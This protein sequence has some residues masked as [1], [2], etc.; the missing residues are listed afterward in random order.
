MSNPS[1]PKTFFLISLITDYAEPLMSF[2]HS[3][4]HSTPETPLLND[5]QVVT[6][7]FQHID[8][9][10]T[11]LGDTVWHEP[12]AHYH[13]QARFDAEI[14][15]L[16]SLPL[17]FCPSAALPEPGSYV[18]RNAAGTPLLVVR[19]NDG[20][21]RAF[22]NACR[23]RG[24]QVASGSGCAKAFVC[25]YHAWTYGLEGNLKHI[26]G[27]AGFPNIALE[28]NGLV[29]VSAAEKGGLVYVL[30]KGQIEPE[31]LEDALDF[32]TPDQTMFQHTQMEEAANWKLL[33]E[34]LLEGYHIKAL[35]RNSFYPFGLDNINVVET[36]GANARV[37]F[38]FRRI[39]KLRAIA[40]EARRLNGTLTSVYHLFPNASVSVLSK[41]TGLTIMEP[42]SPT[43]TQLVR[44]HVVN[45]HQA[46]ATISLEDARRDAAFVT[47][48][49]Q[50]E[51]REA[52]RSI[53]ETVTTGANNHLTFGYFEKAIVNFHQHLKQHL[54]P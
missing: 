35:H 52:A 8:N 7:V 46:N 31:M 27:Q 48:S 38:P 9:G 47:Q 29:E 32:F 37:I 39:E 18:A 49:G 19:G 22:I 41:H 44:Y 50:D 40:P 10:T 12:V 4:S 17:P 51:D 42:L 54:D 15:L 20:V 5:E 16:R 30:Q 13:S 28:D 53:Q 45:R 3:L 26:P 43:Q 24:M 14:A 2:I 33:T 23:H 6:R 36:Y 11:D 1:P 34:T 25:P 21:V